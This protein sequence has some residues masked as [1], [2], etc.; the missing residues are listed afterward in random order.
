MSDEQIDRIREALDAGRL[1]INALEDGSGVLLDVEG[2]QLL[3][4]N[5]TGMRLIQAIADRAASAEE[6]GA[7]LASAYD[8]TPDRAE[9]D[10]RVFLDHVVKA[11]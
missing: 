5:A 3:T 6:L 9:A 4:L 7:R 1:T 11:L 8:V 10:A 2:E